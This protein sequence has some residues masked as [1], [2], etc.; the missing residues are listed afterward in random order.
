MDKSRPGQKLRLDACAGGT[1]VSEHYRANQWRTGREPQISGARVQEESGIGVA[2]ALINYAFESQAD[3]TVVGAPGHGF[4]LR[5][6]GPAVR[7][8][9]QSM[10]TPLL[11]AH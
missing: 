6:A 8:L 5:H 10:V 3:L 7:E 9:L 4:P 2:G 1:A 11:L